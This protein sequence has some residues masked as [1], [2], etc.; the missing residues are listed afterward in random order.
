MTVL[1]IAQV[2]TATKAD[3]PRLARTL[4]LAVHDD[5][6]GR[7]YFPHDA[8]RLRRL[9][10]MFRLLFLPKLAVPHGATYTTDGWTGGALWL[11]PVVEEASPIENLRLL[12][13]MARIWGLGLPHAMRGFEFQEKLHPHEPHYYLN[14]LGVAPEHQGRGIG[15]ALIR[16]IL[17]RCDRDGLPAYLEAT[18]ERNRAL[19]ERHGFRVAQEVRWPNDGPPL[20][21]M[22]REPA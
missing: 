13:T 22:W 5:P 4:A 3:V 6:A 9:E 21:L 17:E 15:S 7:W 1:D 11:P 16:P 18:T 10:R 8:S 12:P 14:I 20:W 2:R 19:Y